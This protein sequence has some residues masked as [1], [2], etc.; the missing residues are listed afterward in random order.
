MCTPVHELSK[1]IHYHPIYKT[2]PV[3]DFTSQWDHKEGKSRHQDRRASS[4]AVDRADRKVRYELSTEEAGIYERFAELL[5]GLES[6]EMDDIGE[7]IVKDAQERKLLQQFGGGEID[8]AKRKTTEQLNGKGRQE[9]H[10][11]VKR[12]PKLDH[13]GDFGKLPNKYAYGSQRPQLGAGQ[14]GVN[15]TFH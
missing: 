8:T 5:A 2:P 15:T 4:S 14:L 6:A 3:L 13:M 12:A 9:V 1:P 10:Q 11:W 7:D